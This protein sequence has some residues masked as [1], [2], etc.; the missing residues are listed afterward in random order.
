MQ[1]QHGVVRRRAGIRTTAARSLLFLGEKLWQAG[2]RCLDRDH[3]VRITALSASQVMG[4]KV[5][6]AL[7]RRRPSAAAQ[8]LGAWGLGLLLLL[9]FVGLELDELLT[10]EAW[11]RLNPGLVGF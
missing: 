11:L 1:Q 8:Q 6:G 3:P 9:D 4:P 2:A 7:P 5:R 10:G